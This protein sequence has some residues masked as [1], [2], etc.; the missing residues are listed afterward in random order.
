MSDPHHGTPVP[1]SGG[2]TGLV[3]G[4]AAMIV[5]GIGSALFGLMG[6]LVG[7]GELVDW[8]MVAF[9]VIVGV[10]LIGGG[11]ALV[12]LGGA[13]P[14]QSRAHT[15][16]APAMSSPPPAGWYPAPDGRGQQYWD[17]Q[18]WTSHRSAPGNDR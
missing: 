8:I 12:R 5:V 2:G 18:A 15:P 11:V 4:G 6:A 13:R 7:D 17:G 1:A 16:S 10:S 3:L 9:F 14:G